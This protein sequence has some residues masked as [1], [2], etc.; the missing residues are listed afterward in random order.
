[1]KKTALLA[2]AFALAATMTFAQTAASP[3]GDAGGGLLGTA[4]G[5]TGL[6]AQPQSNTPASDWGGGELGTA[7]GPTGSSA[8]PQAGPRTNVD[9][10]RI[11]KRHGQ[12]TGSGG[13]GADVRYR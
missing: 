12:T 7:A 13:A 1:M 11:Q 6:S 10:A 2:G 8:Q 4:A 9:I 3:A 5:P